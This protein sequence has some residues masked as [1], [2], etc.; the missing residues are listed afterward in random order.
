MVF[1]VMLFFICDIKRTSSPNK[2]L[3]Y[4]QGSRDA[5]RSSLASL[6]IFW[7]SHQLDVTRQTERDINKNYQTSQTTQSNK[8]SINLG[9]WNSS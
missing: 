7:Q 8:G 5:M 6:Y 3:E 9:G 4:P 2:W 1:G